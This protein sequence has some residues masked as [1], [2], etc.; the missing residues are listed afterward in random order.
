MTET[1]RPAIEYRPPARP[2]A[3]LPI[4]P[5]L[6]PRN[7]YHYALEH[8]QKSVPILRPAPAISSDPQVIA[9]T[10]MFLDL[11]ASI[12]NI[13]P[14]TFPSIFL[15]IPD[16]IQQSSYEAC[17]RFQVASQQAGL[18]LLRSCTSASRST[19]YYHYIEDCFD[20]T[21]SDLSCHGGIKTPLTISYTSSNLAASTIRRHDGM[22][23]ISQHSLD[24]DL[25]SG[26]SLRKDDEVNYW[27]SVKKF[28]KDVIG[29]EEVD[30]LFLLGEN[31]KDQRFREAVK[32]ILLERQNGKS[33][34]QMMG[35]FGKDTGDGLWYG[36]RGAA[37]VAR[38]LM[39]HGGDACLPNAWCEIASYHDEL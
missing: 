7:L 35:G 37:G 28:I 30:T 19:L 11:K 21:E 10:Q 24:L 13:D 1:S 25:G 8:I 26:S 18:E 6:T 15:S 39:W 3:L 22:L 27:V 29:E 2:V 5:N 14:L 17:T 38:R 32:E 31:N 23:E 12:I 34:E 20:E 4:F 36:A 9:L 33:F 16:T